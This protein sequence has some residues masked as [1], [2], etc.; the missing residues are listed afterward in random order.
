VLNRQ[1]PY[2]GRAHEIRRPPPFPACKWEED[3]LHYEARALG[4]VGLP[5][6]DW[7]R[8]G[9]GL[10]AGTK[11]GMFKKT[12]EIPEYDRPIQDLGNPDDEMQD[13]AGPKMN[14][15]R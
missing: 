6:D 14:A 13:S 5:T 9:R 4:I 1:A 15:E 3:K 8:R 12:K 2:H 11:A 7:A 10:E